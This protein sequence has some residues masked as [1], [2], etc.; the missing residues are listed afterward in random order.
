[1]LLTVVFCLGT[2]NSSLYIFAGF[3]FPFTSNG[4]KMINIYPGSRAV[5]LLLLPTW[6][7]V[8]VLQ[9]LVLFYL[10]ILKLCHSWAVE[11]YPIK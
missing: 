9:S 3:F 5:L 1:M 8:T 4:K 11:W 2:W 7:C 6:V 10:T